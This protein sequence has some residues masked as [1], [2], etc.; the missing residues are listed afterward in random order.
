MGPYKWARI[1]FHTQHLR[2]KTQGSSRL[3]APLCQ[4]LFSLSEMPTL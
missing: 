4:W 2:L 1:Y 3:M